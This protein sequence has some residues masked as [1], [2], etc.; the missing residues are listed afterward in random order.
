VVGKQSRQVA[1]LEISIISILDEGGVGKSSLR[2]RISGLVLQPSRYLA[3][4][5]VFVAHLAQVSN[6]GSVRPHHKV[7]R[8]HVSTFTIRMSSDSIDKEGLRFKLR[9]G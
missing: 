4:L 5:T 7:H 1:V 2:P 3:D 6:R 9:W 8:L